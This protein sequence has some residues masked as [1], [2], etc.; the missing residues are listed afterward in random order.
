ME[1]KKIKEFNEELSAIGLLEIKDD[2][3]AD[4]LVELKNLLDDVLS[5]IPK[6]KRTHNKW[7]NKIRDY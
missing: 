2:A 7:R 1:T 4:A 3:K 6:D 5:T